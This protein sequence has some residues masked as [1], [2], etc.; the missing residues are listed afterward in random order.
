MYKDYARS[1]VAAIGKNR[2]KR[3]NKKTVSAPK[4]F[5]PAAKLMWHAVSAMLLIT[6]AI[7][8]TS[9]IWYGWQVRSALDEMGQTKAVNANLTNDNKLLAVKRELMLSQEYMVDAAKKQG[10]SVPSKDQLRYP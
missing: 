7:G 6:L 4:N 2:N 10:L 8:I 5:L 3:R 9:T 1:Y